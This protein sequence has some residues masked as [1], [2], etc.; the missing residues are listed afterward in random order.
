ME[1]VTEG[2]LECQ[3]GRKNNKKSENIKNM[4]K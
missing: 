2:I 1:M 4:G 3:E